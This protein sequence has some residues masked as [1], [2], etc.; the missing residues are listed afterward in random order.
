MI[1]LSTHAE[2]K[3]QKKQAKIVAY[4]R[5]HDGWDYVFIENQ[6]ETIATNIR[7]N[8][9]EWFSN[10]LYDKKPLIETLGPNEFEIYRYVVYD[11]MPDGTKLD[12][13]WDDR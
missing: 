11:S 4:I 3:K 6:G 8:F 9:D 7:V 13:I 5:Y 2:K 12:V 1:N 10:L